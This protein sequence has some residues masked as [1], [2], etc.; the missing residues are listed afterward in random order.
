MA[1]R[2]AR[3]THPGLPAG[4]PGTS[5]PYPSVPA[6][7]TI[8]WM[9][10]QNPAEVLPGLYRAVL[11]GVAR[12]ERAGERQA[13]YEIRR[14]A[15]RVYSTRWDEHGRRKLGRLEQEAK[16]RLAASPRAA[17]TTVLSRSGDPA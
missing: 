12:L 7:A 14:K 15:L 3:A 10:D 13:A 6:A 16:Q 9:D 5:H 4:P 2:C 8:F 11:D 1:P 17:A